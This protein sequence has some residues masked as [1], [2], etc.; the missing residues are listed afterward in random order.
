[1]ISLRGT[2][3]AVLMLGL[4]MWIAPAAPAA[5]LYYVG[6]H[7]DLGVGYSGTGN[8]FE[9]HMHF[10]NSS[11]IAVDDPFGT[12][13][14]ILAWQA[15]DGIVIDREQEADAVVT[16][17]GTPTDAASATVGSYL[18][19]SAGAPYWFL[20]AD[21]SVA[22]AQSKPWLGFGS[23][24]LEAYFL[25]FSN[26]TWTLDGVSGPGEFAAWKDSGLLWSSSAGAGSFQAPI[27]HDHAYFGF[28][29]AGLYQVTITVSAQH[30]LYG[31]VQGTGTYAFQVG[32]PTPAAVPE[33][34]SLAL[35]GIGGI[36]AVGAVIRRRK[37]VR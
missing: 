10:V 8:D 34:S 25:D 4:M 11:R 24:E 15:E 20:P 22:A 18:G 12:S 30:R 26:L 16:Y 1:M 35:L 31:T 13:K 27:G 2:R 29:E 23:E 36:A 32:A 17:V 19:I 5:T 3:R 28:S 6:G 7:A 37:P 14:S 21:S 33:P 9:M